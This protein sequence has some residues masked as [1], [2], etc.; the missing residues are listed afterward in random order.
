MAAS[1]PV[2]LAALVRSV[3]LVEVPERAAELSARLPSPS[4]P[5]PLA[6]GDLLAP[7]R[8]FWRRRRG[9][10]ALPLEREARL[11]WGRR[12][13]RRLGDAVAG[14][15]LLEVRLRRGGLSARIDLLAE[16]P[17]EFKVGASGPV[18]RPE[19][20]EQVGLYAGLVGARAARLVRLAPSDEAAPEVT[21]EELTWRDS[22]PLAEEAARRESALRSALLAG[23]PEGLERCPWFSVGCE[24][25]RAGLCDCRGDEAVRPSPIVEQV[26]RRAPRPEVAERWGAAL[27]L[28][29]AADEVPFVRFRDVL[30]PRRAFFERTRGPVPWVVPPRPPAAPLDL[31][32]RLVAAIELGPAGE[33]HRLVARPGSPEEEVVAWQGRPL[34]LRSSRTRYRLGVDD[35][36]HRFPQYLADLGFRAARSG[37]TDGQLVL[38]HETPDPGVPEVQVF[39]ARFPAGSSPFASDWER[40]R[41]ALAS[42]LADG[43]SERLPACPGWMAAACPYRDA[44]GCEAGPGRSQR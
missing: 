24:Y 27:R 42:A 13:H 35:L 23:T 32:E 36:R 40:R 5:R 31:Y 10:A 21:V 29:P 19:A 39:E 34:L 11:E 17:V 25:R 1:G 37:A 2:D 15:G 9:P 12:W 18:D 20:V 4:A 41:T 7:R 44:C 16:V 33:V 8:A 28:A 43:G 38:G 22:A 30:Y 6:V 26:E 14:D 3:E